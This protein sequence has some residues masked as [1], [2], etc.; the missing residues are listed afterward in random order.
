MLGLLLSKDAMI[1]ENHPNP[2]MLVFT[3][4][5]L[6][7]TLRRVPMR[8]G[9]IHSRVLSDKC[10]CARVKPFFRFLHH[11][12]L[13]KLPTSN[14]RVKGSKPSLLSLYYDQLLLSRLTSNRIRDLTSLHTDRKVHGAFQFRQNM[15][16]LTHTCS[17]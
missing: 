11:F 5:P 1:F 13:A 2:G 8:Q 10:P 14:T 9:F 7:T 16:P 15:F 6:L 4:K 3:G 17:V 12:V